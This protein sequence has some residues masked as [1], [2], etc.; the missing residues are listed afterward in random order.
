VTSA[1]HLRVFQLH[2][3]PAKDTMIDGINPQEGRPQVRSRRSNTTVPASTFSKQPLDLPD[4]K[5]SHHRH[6]H[7]HHHLPHRHAKDSHN[8]RNPTPAFIDHS[9]SSGLGGD[10]TPPTANGSRR[11]SFT[12]GDGIKEDRL[13]IPSFVSAEDLTRETQLV[14][15]RN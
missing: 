1:L 15:A 2:N 3:Q 13:S 6:H 12:G 11:P 14:R 8:V 5:K 4:T 9:K 7:S 10:Y